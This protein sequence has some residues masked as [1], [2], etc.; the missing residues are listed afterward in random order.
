MDYVLE[1]CSESDLDFVFNLK[2]ETMK[3][4]I[5]KIYGWIDE[6][7]R[8]KTLKEIKSNIGN[9]KIIIKDNEKIG[10]TTFTDNKSEYIV[11]LTMIS[12]KF[13][14]KGIATNIINNYIE[15]AKQNKK[16]II[17][18]TYKENPAQN[19]YK[20]LGFKVYDEN[21]THIFLEILN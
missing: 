2:K 13:Q 6:V 5:E 8:Q 11:G 3:W 1:N 16:R 17:I 20:R 19:L 14:N 9:M 4:Y 10:V 15:K 12:P 18:K 21:E 7:Q